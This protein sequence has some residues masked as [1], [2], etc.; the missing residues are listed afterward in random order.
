ML[1]SRPYIA[2]ALYE[3]L[4]ENDNTPYIVVDAMQDDVVVPR[5]FVQNGQI[6]LNV[7]P[8]AVRDLDISNEMITFNA[9]FSGEPMQ[10]WVPIMALVAVYSKENGAGM[11]FGHEPVIPAPEEP[12]PDELAPKLES[13]PK[14]QKDKAASSFAEKPSTAAHD[15]DDDTPPPNGGGRPPKGRPALRVV[16]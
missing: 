8:S 5:Q 2:R 14:A 4:I 13:V 7:A 12:D 3:W 10:V 15:D 6:V 11:V 9:S 1:S 16:K